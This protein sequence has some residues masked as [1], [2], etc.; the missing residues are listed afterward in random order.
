[1]TAKIESLNMIEDVGEITA[2]SIYD[3][4]RQDQTI[5]LINRL[6]QAGVNMTAIEEENVDNRFEG[7]TFVLTGALDKYSRNEASSII[8][9][10][11]G[12]TSSTVS[13]KTNY[14]LAGEDAG[15]KLTKAQALG[16]TIIS[17]KEFEEMI[18]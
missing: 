1:M 2:D 17:E 11:G 9:K 4:F 5:D 13:K 18:K 14:V 7:Q 16:V 15:S 10:Y 3:F 6:K 8:E 12:K